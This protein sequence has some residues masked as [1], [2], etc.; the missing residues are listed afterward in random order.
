MTGQ[1]Q[2]SKLTFREAAQSLWPKI[3]A[4]RE[5]FAAAEPPAA[6]SC[7]KGCGA[8]CHSAIISTSSLEAFGLV[9]AWIGSG[10]AMDDLAQRC[11]TYVNSYLKFRARQGYLPFS[12][13]ARRAFMSERLACPLFIAGSQP[14]E[15]HCGFFEQRPLICT[16]Y[17]SLSPPEACVALDPHDVQSGYLRIGEQL[18]EDLRDVERATF[19]KSAMGHL[20]LLLAA[21][22]TQEGMDAFLIVRDPSVDEVSQDEADISATVTLYAA[23]GISLHDQDIEDLSRAQSEEAP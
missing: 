16:S 10:Q 5:A 3:L 23:A 13:A 21:L 17:H 6:M 7:R 15:G 2:P 8:C 19:G 4:A 20:P 12:R 14:F 9:V 11:H 1:Q 22:L 18:T